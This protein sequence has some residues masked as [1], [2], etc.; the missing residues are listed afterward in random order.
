MRTVFVD[1]D[2]TL[3]IY[4]TGGTH[5]WGD[6]YGEP[7]TPNQKLIDKLKTFKGNIVIWSGGGRD[8]ARRVAKKVLPDTLHYFVGSKLDGK[9]KPQPGD[10]IVDDYK[11]LYPGFEDMGIKVYGPHE[12]WK[13]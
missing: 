6:I 8:Y 7:Y 10:I 1:V 4:E 9:F 13:E 5:H 3:I 2:D 11:G 12:D